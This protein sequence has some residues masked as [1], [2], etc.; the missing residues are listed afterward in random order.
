MAIA[1]IDYGSGNLRSVAKALERAA[2][3]VGRSEIVV[4]TADAHRV[5][6]ADRVVLPGVGSFSDCR[7]GLFSLDGMVDALEEVVKIRGQP[8]MGICVGMQLM[9]RRGLEH[10]ETLGL[11]WIPG[12]VAPITPS[13]TSLK[14]PHMGWNQL[15]L[16][17]TSHPVFEGLPTTTHG[18]FAH[19]FVMQCDIFSDVIA[20]ADYGGI[21]SAAV[22]RGNVVGTQFHPEKSQS[23][24]IKIL[25]NFIKWTP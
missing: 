20:T 5:A 11:G 23:N 24:G 6:K 10:G 22:G 17:Q 1:I 7:A 14:I 8:F 9:A 15:I 21:I 12:D 25:H 4:V 19:S 2:D 18:Y 3:E 16:P 13:D